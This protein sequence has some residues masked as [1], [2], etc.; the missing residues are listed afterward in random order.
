MFKE[1]QQSTM[2]VAKYN[3]KEF[4]TPSYHPPMSRSCS[5]D[6]QYMIL[7]CSCRLIGAWVNMLLLLIPLDRVGSADRVC[8]RLTV[9]HYFSMKYGATPLI[10]TCIYDWRTSHPSRVFRSRA[11]FV[12]SILVTVP[13]S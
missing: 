9:C 12:S 1:L 3:F 11:P 5:Q 6:L 2:M 10:R 8:M 7:L 4:V 13:R